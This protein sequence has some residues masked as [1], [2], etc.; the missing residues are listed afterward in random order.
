METYRGKEIF[1]RETLSFWEELTREEQQKLLEEMEQ[2]TYKAGELLHAADDRCSGLFLL[3]RGQVRVYMVSESGKE[4]TLYRLFERDTCIFS[5]ACMMKNINF[6]LWIEAEKET[7]AYLMPIASY[8]E[9]A[10]DN[11]SVQA[12]M[13]DLIEARFSDVMWVVEQVL[14]SSFDRRLADFLLEQ[15]AIEE[16]STLLMT[17]EKIANNLGTARE[18][19]TRMLKYFQSEGIVRIFRGGVEVIDR[20]KLEQI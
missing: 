3:L 4:I 7:D 12:F 5:A 9:L 10:R 20:K 11:V 14:F 18:V 1:F 19:V 16:S 13:N 8:Q 15:M 6:D 2:R 17:H